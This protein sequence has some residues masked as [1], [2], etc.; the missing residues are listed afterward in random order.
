MCANSINAKWSSESRNA[1]MTELHK[2][3]GTN[4]SH[5]NGFKA[6]IFSGDNDAICST[7]GTQSWIEPAFEGLVKRDWFS[8]TQESAQYGRQVGGFGVD[9][10]NGYRF[11]TVHGAGHMVPS[12]QP[13]RALSLLKEFLKNDDVKAKKDSDLFYNIIW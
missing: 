12:T 11:R 10:T 4:H 6:L 5:V 13:E 3:I 7:L 9:Q 1:D 2:W 8:W